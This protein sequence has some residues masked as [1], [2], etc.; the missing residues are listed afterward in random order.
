MILVGLFRA[1]GAIAQYYNQWKLWHYCGSV[2]ETGGEAPVSS[3]LGKLGT[4]Q[5]D[6]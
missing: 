1:I 6:F 4:G 3:V 2:E 5:S